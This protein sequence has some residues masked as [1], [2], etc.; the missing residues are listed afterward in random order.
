M[1][2]LCVIFAIVDESNIAN[3][4]GNTNLSRVNDPEISVVLF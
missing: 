4:H 3:C 2:E 1:G